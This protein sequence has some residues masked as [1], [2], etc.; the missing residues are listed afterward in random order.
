MYCIFLCSYCICIYML[1]IHIFIYICISSWHCV[2]QRLISV[3]KTPPL[4]RVNVLPRYHT[5]THGVYVSMCIRVYIY[6]CI[7]FTQSTSTSYIN[8]FALNV[9]ST[10][11]GILYAAA[12]TSQKSFELSNNF[13]EILIKYVYIYGIFR[14]IK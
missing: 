5:L 11:G 14:S 8:I 12:V 10:F 13:H 7:Y 6:I 1:D 2:E 3:P 9:R 4:L